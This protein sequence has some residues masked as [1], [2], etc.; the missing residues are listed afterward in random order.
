ML[1]HKDYQL[2]CRVENIS[3]SGVLVR[4][5]ASRSKSIHSD[6]KFE[7]ILDN[8]KSEEPVHI[9]VQVVH[10]A[11]TYIGL[12]FPVMN[13]DIK[14]VIEIFMDILYTNNSFEP[15]TTSNL[16]QSLNKYLNG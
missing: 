16:Y 15:K 7:M 12:K 6:E 9:P 1:K 11:F 13:E 3:L 10:H 8:K 5:E 14:D 4:I 2:P